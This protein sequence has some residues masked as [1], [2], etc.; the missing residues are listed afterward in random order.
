MNMNN[1][2]KDLASVLMISR[3]I[4]VLV[5]CATEKMDVTNILRNC[6]LCAEP[7]QVLQ[8]TSAAI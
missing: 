5:D 4:L 6:I 7:G 8:C 3:R 1:Y 2:R